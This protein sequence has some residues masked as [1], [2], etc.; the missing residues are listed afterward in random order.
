MNLEKLRT[1]THTFA[2]DTNGYVFPQDT[3]DMF[4]NM[5]IDV[6]REYPV[7]ADMEY[8]YLSSDVPKF[9]PEK[10]H[11]IIALYA[12]SRCFDMDERFYEGT[13]KRNEF[14]Q[15]LDDLIADIEAGNVII[16]DDEGKEVKNTYIASDEVVNDYFDVVLKD[17]DVIPAESDENEIP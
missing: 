4:I 16:T 9:L 15:K 3:V 1:M 8:L 14:E 2:R 10:Y 12:S 6:L 5:A 17:S 13:E 11:Y 7:F